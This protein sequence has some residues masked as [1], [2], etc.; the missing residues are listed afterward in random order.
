[1]TGGRAGGA[2]G[3]RERDWEHLVHNLRTGHC[4]PFLG[5]GACAD[6]IPLGGALAHEWAVEC[7]YPFEDTTDLTRVMQYVA[8]RRFHGDLT[9]L[10]Q[11]V[12]DRVFRP[13]APPNSPPPPSIHTLLAKCDLPIYVTT[14]Y[15][16]LLMLALSGQGKRPRIGISP[17]YPGAEDV[18]E[19]PL[20]PQSGYRPSPQEPLVFHMHGHWR[21]PESL[22]LAEDD[23]IEYLIGLGGESRVAN[24]RRMVPPP[25]YTALRSKPVLFIGYS[26]RDWTFQVLF[27]TLMR[28]IA[29]THRRWHVSVQLEPP[30]PGASESAKSYL[31]EYFRLR[32]ITVFWES[33]DSF[34][35]EL[36]R[37]MWGDDA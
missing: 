2:G 1:M 15:D 26:L 18:L 4:T 3:D 9:T 34:T 11:A 35:R 16:D 22:V 21:H 33:T 29:E 14:N 6:H 23:Y 7:G 20:D 28:D 31:E 27:R 25:V 32:H 13:I 19:Q 5:A 30:V 24:G 12:V 10:K 36:A 37:R 8:V 17:W